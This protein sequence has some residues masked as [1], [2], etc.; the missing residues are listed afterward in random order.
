MIFLEKA[1]EYVSAK[2]VV[3]KTKSQEWFGY[4][5]NM[6][7]YKGCCHGCIYCDSRS[8]C[9]HIEQFEFCGERAGRD[10]GG[11]VRAIGRAQPAVDRLQG[12][13]FLFFSQKSIML[14]EKKGFTKRGSA[15]KAAF[16]PKRPSHREEKYEI[17]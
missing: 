9:Y 3:T 12:A 1:M 5:Y 15:P 6:N 8:D 11:A 2:T 14:K 4:D 10:P 17:L 13:A 16:G 7:L